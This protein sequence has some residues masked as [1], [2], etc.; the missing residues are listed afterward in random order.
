VRAF[1]DALLA[2]PSFFTLRPAARRILEASQRGE[3]WPSPG[4]VEGGEER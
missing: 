3:L 2:E 1:E 4:P